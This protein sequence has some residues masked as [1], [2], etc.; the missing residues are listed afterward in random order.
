MLIP[1]K[2]IDFPWS[3]NICATTF[4]G[5]EEIAINTVTTALRRQFTLLFDIQV[6]WRKSMA[7]TWPTMGCAPLPGSLNRPTNGRKRG[8]K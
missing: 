8:G 4:D 2:K 7:N 3:K 1:R 6:K 5:A